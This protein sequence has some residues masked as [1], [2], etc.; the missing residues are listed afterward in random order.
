[1]TRLLSCLVLCLAFALLYHHFRKP[2]EEE[3][4]GAAARAE[5]PLR[6]AWLAALGADPRAGFPAGLPWAGL[7]GLE[8]RGGAATGEPEPGPDGKAVAFLEA[9]LRRYDREVK[10]YTA[11]L[12]KRDWA[13]GRLYP[14]EV[15]DC[16]FREKPFSVLMKWKSG[17]RQ[18][19]AA[20]YV[21][22]ENDNHIVVRPAGLASFL[23]S[24][25]ER[26]LDS[27]DVKES[28]RYGIEEFGMRKAMERVLAGWRAA[29]PTLHVTY[30]GV[31][32]VPQAGDRP[33]YKLHRTRYAQPDE[34]G[35]ADLVLYIDV[36]TGLQ[37]GSILRGEDGRLLGEYYFRDV[38]LNPAFPP[39]QF[40]RVALAR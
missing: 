37:T 16:W 23:V 40:T 17:E 31:F 8:P 26:P 35:T 4:P 18:A 39:D 22:G 14:T 25:V 20:L 30:E 24:L 6:P 34:D 19:K 9:C 38:R 33:C 15:V 10:G 7:F 13:G 1:M 27:P 2:A 36:E 28:G 11:V 32:R 3:R 29:G 5:S 12:Q 21:A